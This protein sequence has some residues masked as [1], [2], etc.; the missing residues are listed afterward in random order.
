MYPFLRLV[1]EL[2]KFRAAPPLP[3]TGSH[4]SQHRCW[5]WD[6]DFMLEL[7]NGR[8]LTF[9]DLGRVVLARRTGL[10]GA[11]RRNGW[12]IT[13]AGNSLRY[14]R[15]VR[16]FD[17]IEMHSR[18]LGWDA[19]FFYTEQSM[20]VGATCTSH[21][22]LRGAVTDAGGIVAPVRVLAALGHD[23]VPDSPALP[24]WV[25]AWIAG[26]ALR[27]WPPFRGS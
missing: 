26:D 6:L 15:R 14:R 27:P 20:W 19:R 16:V 7:N 22:L 8:T 11:L 23:A 25:Q 17:R 1:K 10:H 4:V 9:Y 5:P 2:A 18:C 13:V 21:M 3:I 24:E 12:G